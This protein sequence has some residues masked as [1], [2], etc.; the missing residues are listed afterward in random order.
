M[1]S[2]YQGKGFELSG[3]SIDADKK[4]FERMV[5]AKQI[6]WPQILDGKSGDGPVARLF[7]LRGTPLLYLI[8]R[9]GNIA[10]KSHSA[11]KIK[12]MLATALN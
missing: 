8:D 2:N 7:N 3:V 1:Y 12:S 4:A 6:S 10:A 5:A 9:D 11:E